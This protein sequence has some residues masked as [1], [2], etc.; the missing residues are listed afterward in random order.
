M[1]GKTG[2][3]WRPDHPD[4]EARRNHLADLLRRQII[5]KAKRVARRALKRLKRLARHE[6]PDEGGP[7]RPPRTC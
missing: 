7:G 3:G 5:G 4:E 2:G 6:T 1:S